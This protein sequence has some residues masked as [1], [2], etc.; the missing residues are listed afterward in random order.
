V[1]RSEPQEEFKSLLWDANL[2]TE[3]S[4]G[5]LR[6]MINNKRTAIL[7]HSKMEHLHNFMLKVEN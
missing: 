5:A 6:I 3:I 7:M 4:S 1:S 2:K